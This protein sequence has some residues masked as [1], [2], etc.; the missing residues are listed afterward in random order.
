[1]AKQR[2]TIRLQDLPWGSHDIKITD[3]MSKRKQIWTTYWKTK[4]R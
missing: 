3:Y 4:L 1:M 2:N